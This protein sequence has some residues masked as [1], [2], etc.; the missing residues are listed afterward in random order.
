MHPLTL[1]GPGDDAD[2]D[3]LAAIPAVAMLVARVRF[4]QPDF[5]V[6][7]A[8]AAAIAEICQRLDGLPLA[9]EL[10]AP[11]AKLFTLGELAIRLRHR[12]GLLTSSARDAPDRHRTLRAALEWSHDLLAPDERALFRRLSVFAGD[13][14]LDAADRV[15]AD[16]GADVIET[17][18][19]LVD[20]SLVQRSARQGE[21]AEFVLLESLREFAAELLSEH[22]DLA[23]SRARHAAY[24]AELATAQEAR[25]GLPAEVGWWR[26]STASH[27]ANL[28]AALDHCLEV[29]DTAPALQLAA[30]LGWHSY[31][32]G[33]I[34]A[35]LAQLSRALAAADVAEQ[36]NDALAGALVAA[37]VL[38]M[39][40]GD[41]DQANARLWSGLEISEAA[42]DGRRTAIASSFLGHLARAAGEH[43]EARARHEQA[44]VLYRRIPSVSGY[45]WTRYD[46]G[47][48][49]QR[50]GDLDTAAQSLQD[51]FML[52]REIDYAWAIGRCAWA[53]AVVRL[54]RSETD[55]AAALLAEALE[56]HEQVGDN[57]GLAQC[58]E[59]AAGVSCARGF[60]DAAA[61]LLGAAAGHRERLAAPLP[62]ED[63]DAHEEVERAVRRALGGDA[64]DR[65]KGAGRAMGTADAVALA[66][67]VV[68][69]RPA[70]APAAVPAE[71]DD[72]ARRDPPANPLTGRERQVAD[73]IAAGRTNR[74]IGRALGIA[75][76]TVEVH[77]HHVI[78]KLGVHSRTE[79]A[80]W[81]VSQHYLPLH[82]S[83]DTAR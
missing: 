51:G 1:P 23:L 12:M 2:P 44:A 22:D 8:N 76:K 78:A 10:T 28:A 15:C 39:A 60:P 64:A 63:R 11:R 3:R 68:V 41:L 5:A 20:K 35:G 40:L 21:V 55:E 69:D 81:V 14:T 9:L 79:V 82:G 49:A 42:G 59:S 72:P 29:G 46:L 67:T 30:A 58:L 45:A 18:G 7:E 48:L 24:F 37:G 27:E 61:R 4:I 47:L 73:L 57:R 6:T 56:R 13:W 25:I 74:Q 16:A 26:E 80:A 38:A 31:L 33:N 36:P 77:V 75:E 34:G 66:R 43:D 54:R 62:D 50:Q 19:S 17:V 65:S 71:A 52:F 53:L 70:E 83:P 32:R